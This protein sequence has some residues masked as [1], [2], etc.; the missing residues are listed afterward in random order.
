MDA[1]GGVPAWLHKQKLVKQ[2]FWTARSLDEIAGDIVEAATIA[3]LM[4][5]LD[6]L[7][8][9][10]KEEAG[11]V[12]QE[13]VPPPLLL[14]PAQEAKQLRLSTCRW[15]ETSKKRQKEVGIVWFRWVRC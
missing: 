5:N 2:A 11:V 9:C 1:L 13:R 12:E 3:F 8:E 6:E 10:D 7:K 14:L 4:G 15:K